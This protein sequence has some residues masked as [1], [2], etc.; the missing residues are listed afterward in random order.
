MGRVG[1]EPTTNGLKGHAKNKQLLSKTQSFVDRLPVSCHFGPMA[2][3][4]GGKSNILRRGAF[5]VVEFTNGSGTQ[6]F[7]VVGWVD[8]VRIRK[9]FADL[10]SAEAHKVELEGQRVGVSAG[11][12]VR[13]IQLTDDQLA[14]CERAAALIPDPDELRRAFT[15]WIEGGRAEA[16]SKDEA[17]AVG[18]DEAVKGF[19]R[20]LP[21]SGLRPPTQA[22]LKTRVRTFQS[23]LG[24]LPMRSLDAD[25]IEAWLLSRKEVSEVSRS[26]DRR[27]IGRFLSWCVARPQRFIATNPVRDVKLRRMQVKDP[28]VFRVRE[29]LRLLAAARQ[30]RKGAFLRYVTLCVFAGLR[31]DEAKRIG[32][33]QISI[34]DR[35]LRITPAQSK[36]ERSRVVELS[37]VAVAWIEEALAVKK[38]MT[39]KNRKVWSGLLRKARI[40]RWITDGLR[41]SALSLHLRA[42][43]SFAET[44]TWGGTSETM[45]RKHYVGRF[46]AAEA[47]LFARLHPDR[48]CRAADRAQDEKTI[49]FAA[50]D[51]AAVAS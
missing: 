9:N 19:L 11:S 29:L 20:W 42:S 4:R 26:N 36:A 2:T 46:S 22:N 6:S 34:P 24:D 50:P 45:L 41:H 25:K 43:G 12:R 48:K 49:Q 3:N 28:E 16:L 39:S 37:P 13:A 38:R 47:D 27:A 8:G 15:Y 44:A 35:E 40:K 32:D 30:Y 23:D 17:G 31:P 5:R 10:R 14:V 7:R 51:S 18:L 21:T 1:V 33:S